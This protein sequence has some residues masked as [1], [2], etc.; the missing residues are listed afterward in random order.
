[1]IRIL[2]TLLMVIH[3]GTKS[4]G[5]HDRLFP[6]KMKSYIKAVNVDFVS[7]RIEN[8]EGMFRANWMDKTL[9]AS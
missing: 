3:Q 1:M 5:I 7:S 6:G 9:I 2:S 4:D 8:Y